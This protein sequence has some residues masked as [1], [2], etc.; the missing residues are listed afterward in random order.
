MARFIVMIGNGEMHTSTP[1]IESIDTEGFWTNKRAGQSIEADCWSSTTYKLD[2]E[3]AA[4]IYAQEWPKVD[5]NL[6]I[7]S[8]FFFNLDCTKATVDFFASIMR[9][10]VL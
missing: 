1:A 10:P 5:V 6:N 9:N 4:D 8:S 3:I 7:S 2:N